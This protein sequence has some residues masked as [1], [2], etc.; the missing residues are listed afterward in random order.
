MDD[1][2]TFVEG[3]L[4]PL[5]EKYPALL[6]VLMGLGTLVVVATIVVAITKTKK[7]DA[8]LAKVLANPF[9]A[10]FYNLLSKF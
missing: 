1:L 2:I 4:K 3:F 9:G 8:V 7:D 5:A 6:Y 10:F